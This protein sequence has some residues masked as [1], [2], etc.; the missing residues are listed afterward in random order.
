MVKDDSNF[1][2]VNVAT[3]TE[4]KIKDLTTEKEYSFMEAICEILNDVKEIKKS[5]V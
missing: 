4:P 2:I 5:T 1:E 3:A